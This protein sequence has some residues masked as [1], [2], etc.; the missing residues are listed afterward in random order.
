MFAVS[1][2][3]LSLL[4]SSASDYA[5]PVGLLSLAFN[6]KRKY[7]RGSRVGIWREPV[8]EVFPVGTFGARLSFDLTD[9]CPLS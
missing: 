9:A 5:C 4:Q 3:G 6:L 7:R 2:P 1:R 8:H